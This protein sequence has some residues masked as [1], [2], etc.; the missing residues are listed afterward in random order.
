MS[1]SPPARVTNAA[2]LPNDTP[3]N[4]RNARAMYINFCR[5]T[6]TPEEMILD[7]ALQSE[8]LPGDEALVSPQRIT[9]GLYTAR[10]L[11]DAL[12]MSLERY[13]ATFGPVDPTVGNRIVGRKPGA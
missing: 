6:S 13:E 10:R 12:A 4:L 5:V 11:F 2:Q 7:F 3:I 1:E 8:L 9:L